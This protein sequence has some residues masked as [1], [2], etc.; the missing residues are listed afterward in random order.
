[1][2]RLLSFCAKS[3]QVIT[4]L[5]NSLLIISVTDLRIDLVTDIFKFHFQQKIY[6]FFPIFSHFWN[7]LLK[8][9]FFEKI[10]LYQGCLIKKFKS[11]K[12]ICDPISITHYLIMYDMSIEWYFIKE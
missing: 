7:K 6:N 9:I 12:N 11:S 3:S 8:Q 1:M 5:K 4:I 2:F 10:K